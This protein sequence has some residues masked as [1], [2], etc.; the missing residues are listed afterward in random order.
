MRWDNS[1]FFAIALF[2]ATLLW[3]ARFFRTG[4]Q[5]HSCLDVIPRNRAYSFWPEHVSIA[6]PAQRKN[7]NQLIEVA[8]GTTHIQ[9]SAIR[10]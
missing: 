5:R 3:S 4:R 6:E 7:L 10:M 1:L 9:Q 8:A 2:L